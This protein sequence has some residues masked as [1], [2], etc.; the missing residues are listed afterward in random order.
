MTD[1]RKYSVDEIDEMRELLFELQI[2]KRMKAFSRTRASTGGYSEDRV[3]EQAERELRTYM[4]AGT[5]PAEI[6]SRLDAERDR[7][8]R[9]QEAAPTDEQWERY[10]NGAGP[11]AFTVYSG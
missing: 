2:A 9:D 4:L 7:L 3:R 1:Q 6:R 5:S 8:R 10:Y 11:E